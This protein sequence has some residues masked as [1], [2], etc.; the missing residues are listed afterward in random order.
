MEKK[1]FIPAL[2]IASFIVGS[3][4]MILPFLPFGWLLYGVSALLVVPY[5][6]RAKKAFGWVADKDGTGSTS[7]ISNKV[8]DLY[9]W[10]DEDEKANEVEKAA[11]EGV[12]AD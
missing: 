1:Y 9:R 8:A 3:V 12:S 2:A 6:K 10:A 4:S 5:F 11:E 7:K